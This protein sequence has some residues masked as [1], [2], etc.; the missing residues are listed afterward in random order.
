MFGVERLMTFEVPRYSG[1]TVCSR[2]LWACKSTLAELIFCRFLV[3]HTYD[4]KS[5]RI[6]LLGT[7]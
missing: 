5:E 3:V 6:L 7:E 4:V 2:L 1:E